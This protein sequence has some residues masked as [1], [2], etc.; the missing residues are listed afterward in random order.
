MAI[1]HQL[2]DQVRPTECGH[3]DACGELHFGRKLQ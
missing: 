3:W 1:F 2:T